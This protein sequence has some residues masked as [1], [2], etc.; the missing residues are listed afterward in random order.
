MVMK[1]PMPAF[2]SVQLVKDVVAERA[3][4]VNATFF[5][6]IKDEWCERVQEYI[7][8][9]GTPPTVGTWPAI[10]TKKKSFLNL[11][12]SP[13]PGSVQSPILKSMRKHDLTVCPACGELGRPNTLDHYLPKGKYPHFCITPVNLF[14][15]CDACQDAKD[16]KVGNAQS[17][18]FFV[19]P[20]F[21]TF[22]GQQVLHL[23]IH[24]PFDAP[25]FTLGASPDLN[26]DH[27]AL[28]RTHVRELKIETRYASFFRNQYRR[29]LR[30]VGAMRTSGQNVEQTLTTFKQGVADPS[31][32]TWE[33]V[34]YAAVLGNPDH[35]DYLANEPLPQYL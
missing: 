4:G 29:L 11:Y 21:D 8:N 1:L 5:N 20:Y 13:A 12:L 2:D 7:D 23:E 27:A 30:L 6:N 22:V 35:L 26:A 19:H 3:G 14:P 10:H 28:I 9:A 25:S 24:P 16:T 18:R 15:M 31:L 17:P 34:F 32:N 33:H